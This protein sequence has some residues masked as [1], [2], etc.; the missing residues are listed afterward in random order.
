[1]LTSNEFMSEVARAGREASSV[2]LLR[3]ATQP[4]SNSS[5]QSASRRHLV[6]HTAYCNRHRTL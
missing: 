1:M 3:P 6:S 5:E 2:S 4:V